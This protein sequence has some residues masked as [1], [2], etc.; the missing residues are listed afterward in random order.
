MRVRV[1]VGQITGAFNLSLTAL[2]LLA[3]VVGMFLIYNT[4]TFSVV[5]RRPIIGILRSL[6]VTRRQIFGMI[7]TEA[8]LLSVIGVI[9]GLIAGILLGRLAVVAVTQTVTSLYFTVT[10]RNVDIPTFALVKGAVIGVAAALF[11]ALL[12]AYEATTTP[13]AGTLKRSDIEGK[14]RRAVPYVT[15]L[16]VLIVLASL[17]ALTIPS[18][19][20][21]FTALFGIVV[22]FSLFTPLVALV[23]MR[24][25]RPIT[26]AV[27]GVLGLIAPRSIIRSLSRTSV[28]VAALMVAVS[29]IVGV[30]AMV[31]SFRN[32]VTAWLADT[33]RADI[34]IGP[35]SIS[36][37]RQEVPVDPKYVEEVANTPGVRQVAIVRNAEAIRVGDTR[38]VLLTAIDFDTSLGARRFVWAIGSYDEVWQ[39]MGDGAVIVSETFARQRDIPIGPEQT[40]TLLTEKGEQT[41]PIA[42][43]MFDYSGD[44]GTVMLRLPV[45]HTFYSDRAVSNIAAFVTEGASVDEVVKAIRDKFAE[46][47][48]LRV[49]SNREL[50]DSV[51]VVF[52]QTFAITTALN[53]LATVVAFIGILSALAS[54]QLERV[55]EFGAMRANGMTRRQLFR[56]TLFETGLMGAIAGVMAV[57]VG[58]VLAWVLVYII[59]IRSFGW[60]LTLQLRPE[61]Y[62]QALLVSLVAALLAGIYPALRIGLIQPARALR[63]E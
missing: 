8:L 1:P 44:Q 16:G 48:E 3:L 49:Q 17:A 50:R 15:L 4:V 18:L 12:P 13:L 25:I 62:A 9:I 39:A 55:R 22:G 56:L 32:D 51:L 28:A 24:L 19:E 60:T 33:I 2:S 23:G 21:S 30:S 36:A 53:M 52:D 29:V 26:G 5:Q 57:P 38:P 58:T 20:V 45:Y 35:P 40:I 63:L 46:R 14:V 31:G 7:L 43:F 42:A 41:F 27:A 54:L 10:V 11:A 61:F 59:N 37:I 6:G 34:F 47:V